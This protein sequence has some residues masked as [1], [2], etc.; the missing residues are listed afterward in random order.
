MYLNLIFMLEWHAL[1]SSQPVIC[2]CFR[3]GGYREA[4]LGGGK[5]GVH[6]ETGHPSLT[7]PHRPESLLPHPGTGGLG[8]RV[9]G[10]IQ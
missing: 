8:R 2:N 5:D 9:S 10:G 3:F 1:N 7:C 6:R 4:V